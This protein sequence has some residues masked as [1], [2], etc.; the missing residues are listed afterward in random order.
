MCLSLGNQKT[1]L[2]QPAD[3][4]GPGRRRADAL[5]FLQALP[6]NLIVDKTPGILHRLDQS[7]FVVTRRRSGLLVLDFGV[8]QLRGLAVAQRRQQL[9]LV[10]LFVGGLP[11][12]EC[13]APAEIDGLTAG[14]AEF[15]A[16][17]VE[18][19][20][21]LPVA[22]VGH[23]GGEIG[24]RDDVEQFLLVRRQTRPDLRQFVDRVDVGNDGVMARALQ[25]LV[26]ERA[27]RT[28]TDDRRLGHGDR[29]ERLAHPQAGHDPRH[30]RNQ[31]LPADSAPRRAGK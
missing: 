31:A 1:L 8:L 30:V 24:P 9:R 25:P 18:R 20:G 6:Q 16:A 14:G 29:A 22:E 13:R 4:L 12:R 3:D 15:E 17:H 11:I 27:A 19:C 2:L 5:G 7:A 23:Q 26:V 28:L 10:A 21:C